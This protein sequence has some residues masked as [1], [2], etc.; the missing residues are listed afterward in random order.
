MAFMTWTLSRPTT[1]QFNRY[2]KLK[3]GEPWNSDKYELVDPTAVSK[4][5]NQRVRGFVEMLEKYPD[6]FSAIG[7]HEFGISDNGDIFNMGYG[8]IKYP[9]GYFYNNPNMRVLS[10]DDSEIER[11]VPTSLRYFMLKNPDIRWAIQ[12]LA[13][14][15]LSGDRVT[16]ILNNSRKPLFEAVGFQNDERATFEPKRDA[17]GDIIYVYAQD[18]FIRQAKQIAKLYLE[19]GFPIADIEID[20][21]K[22]WSVDGEDQLFADLLARVKREICI[23]LGLGLR[24]NLFAMTGDYNPSYYGWHNYATV[25]KAEVDGVQAVDEFQL[26]TYDFSWGGS[27]AGASTPLWWLENVLEHVKDLEERGLWKAKDVYIGNAGYGRRW[28]LNEDRMGVTFDFKQMVQMQN[29]EYIHN[30]GT[31]IPDPNDPSKTV[32][33]FRDQDFIP[34][35]GYNDTE[36][37][38]QI[39]Y[40]HVYDRFV[41]DQNGGAKFEAVNRPQGANYVTNYSLTQQPIFTGVLDHVAEPDSKS[42]RFEPVGTAVFNNAQGI[43]PVTWNKYRALPEYIHPDTGEPTGLPED[44]EGR[45]TYTLNASGTFRILMMVNF[46]FYGRDKVVVYVNGTP[47]TVS[48]GDWYSISLMQRDH[49][50]DLGEFSAT[51]KVTI[52]IGNTEGVIVGGFV[53]SKG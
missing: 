35:A 46:P 26:M 30:D 4:Y 34:F 31:T 17:N 41:L 19:A 5:S 49:F 14:S 40:P 45:F 20:M 15:N 24:V 3:D 9:N 33:P 32:F 51:G 8:N 27:S 44:K 25:A 1:D 37:D 36:S 16:P 52:E 22:T 21:E 18:E 43:G 23:P 53:A 7:M 11:P 28:A 38:Y 50:Y 6:K 13:T 29:G 10:D 2:Y 12:F 42:G 47:V 48:T 39:N